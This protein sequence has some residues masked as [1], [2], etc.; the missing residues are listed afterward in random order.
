MRRGEIAAVAGDFGPAGIVRA[1]H[2]LDPDFNATL[3]S[4]GID[5]M[6]ICDRLVLPQPPPGAQIIRAPS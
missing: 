5:R 3:R 1:S 2:A 4:F 6:V